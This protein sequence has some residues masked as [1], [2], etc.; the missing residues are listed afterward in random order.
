MQVVSVGMVRRFITSIWNSHTTKGY[1]V[2]PKKILK[3]EKETFITLIFLGKGHVLCWHDTL[4]VYC[5]K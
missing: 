4:R 1:R 3:G 2:I 5:C